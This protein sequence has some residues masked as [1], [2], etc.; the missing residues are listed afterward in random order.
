MQ[1]TY[2]QICKA[3]DFIGENHRLRSENLG[4]RVEN[5]R[6]SGATEA[7]LLGLRRG[8]ERSESPCQHPG[9]VVTADVLEGDCRGYAVAHCNACGAVR[10]SF[11][12]EDGK[13]YVGLWRRPLN[14]IVDTSDPAATARATDAVENTARDS[15]K[16]HSPI[17]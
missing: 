4:L 8:V 9:H 12:G 15:T 16:Q 14:R 5:E 2:D 10:V 1:L 11:E 17:T 7:L 6:L 13:G 3:L